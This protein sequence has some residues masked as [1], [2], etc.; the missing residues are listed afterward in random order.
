MVEYRQ[1]S[2]RDSHGCVSLV[3]FMDILKTFVA[4]MSLLFE[5]GKES[6]ENAD[7]LQT[8]SSQFGPWMILSHRRNRVRNTKNNTLQISDRDTLTNTGSYFAVLNDSNTKMD[9]MPD[10]EESKFRKS[11]IGERSGKD[12]K[13][14]RAVDIHSSRNGRSLSPNRKSRSDNKLVRFNK[15]DEKFSLL[16]K[17]VDEVV[18]FKLE[19]ATET[20][21]GGVVER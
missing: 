19:E 11:F 9:N 12:G 2:M 1:L 4:K 17:D 15:S 16:T 8:E 14:T 5:N 21:Y 3:E 13:N 20:E 10:R 7:E 18:G 6:G